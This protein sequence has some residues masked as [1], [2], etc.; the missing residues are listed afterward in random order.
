[1]VGTKASIIPASTGWKEPKWITPGTACGPALTSR[2]MTP[3]SF[4][5][6]YKRYVRCYRT[7]Q[8]KTKFGERLLCLIL[9]GM[10]VS[11]ATH[12][13]PGKLHL[14]PCRSKEIPLLFFPSIT[15]LAGADAEE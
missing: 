10:R 1:M 13:R 15:Q 6:S 2:L 3:A 4:F 14:C 12:L 11:W 9:H 7:L 5:P 8:R